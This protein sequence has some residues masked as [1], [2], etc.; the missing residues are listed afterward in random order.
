MIEPI[1]TTLKRRLLS[2]TLATSAQAAYV[3]HIANS[4]ADKR[5]RAI[6]FKDQELTIETTSHGLGHDLKHETAALC[7]TINRALNG[8]SV[9]RVRVTVRSSPRT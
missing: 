9:R 7:G 5:W 2:R 4:L 8:V 3:C 1:A 6:R